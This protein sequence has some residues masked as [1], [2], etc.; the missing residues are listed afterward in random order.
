VRRVFKLINTEHREIV[1]ADPASYFDLLPHAE[2]LKP[3]A[4]RIVDGAM[5]HLIKMWLTGPV[6]E[7]DDRGRKHRNTR[8]R[9]K[10]RGTPR[11]S[12]ISPRPSNLYMRRFVRGCKK[13]RHEERLGVC[14]V[15]YADDLEIC[16]RSSAEEALAEMRSMMTKLKLTVNETKTRV[17]RLP[18]EKFDFLGYTFGLSYLTKTAPL[19]RAAN[20]A[21]TSSLI[22]LPR[23]SKLVI[24]CG[25]LRA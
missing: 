18:E 16:C 21:N 19:S 5:L 11:G 2:L 6:E 4:L 3:V 8:N 10:G 25:W 15:N 22:T 1:D 12:P 7:T 9:D 20:E 17:A 23:R 13:L 14:I 24:D